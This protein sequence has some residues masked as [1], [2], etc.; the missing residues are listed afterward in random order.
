MEK[1]SEF[2]FSR[3]PD[4][5]PLASEKDKTDAPAAS[6]AATRTMLCFRLPVLN[7]HFPR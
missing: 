3:E 1:K 7:S 6:S 5:P 4:F 2:F